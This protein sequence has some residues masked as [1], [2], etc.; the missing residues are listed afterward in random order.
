MNAL[1]QELKDR[2]LVYQTSGEEQLASALDDGPITLYCG[3]DPTADS[4]HIGHLLPIVTLRRFQLAGHKPIALVGGGTGLIGD[5]SFKATERKLNSAETVAQWAEGIK[6]QLEPFLSFDGPCA[7]QMANNFEWLGNL[8]LL[9]FLRDV[10]KNFSVNAMVARDSVRTRLERE[11]QGLSFTEFTYI[12][13]QSY[14]FAQLNARKGCVLQIGGSDQWGNIASGIDLA[15]RLN[16]AQCH[17]MTLPLMT[18][19]DGKKFGKTESGAV[20]LS[21]EKTSPYAFYQFWLKTADADVCKFLRCFTFLSLEEIDAIERADKE[22]GGKPQAQRRL[23]EEV[24]AL[25]HGKERL[26]AAKRITEA[27]FSGDLG[28]LGEDDFGQLALDG[29]PCAHFDKEPGVV[30][31]L[32]KGA[33]AK[34]NNEARGFIAQGGVSVNGQKVS[35]AAA[36]VSKETA[37]FG[38]YAV[39]KRGK[40]NHALIVLD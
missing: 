14:D 11:G 30:E 4:L 3:F 39:V 16:Q 37:F 36:L 32:T 8:N 33:L 21:A 38:K 35:D 2:G 7:A 22:G 31:A 5:P 17:G 10:G 15:R 20:W 34:S 26:A 12:L 6:K 25:V 28:R 13:L 24:T 9:E 29:L 19:A 1:F 40:R 27:L 23:A 18:K